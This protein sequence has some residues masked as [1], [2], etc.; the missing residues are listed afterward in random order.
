M[1]R[2]RLYQA[3]NAAALLA[4]KKM[5]SVPSRF[6]RELLHE[7]RP[8]M[9]VSRSASLGAPRDLGHSAIDVL[10]IRLG[11]NVQHPQFGGGVVIDYGCDAHARVQGQFDEVGAKW[12]VMAQPNLTVI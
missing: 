11:A 7:V 12:L 9:Q 4:L 8:K 2:W 6:L 10:A 1:P 5:P 3:C